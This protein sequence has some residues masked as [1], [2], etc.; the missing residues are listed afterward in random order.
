MRFFSFQK[1]EI[2]LPVDYTL[3]LPSQIGAL[4]TAP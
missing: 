1:E 4:Y 3:D 2:H